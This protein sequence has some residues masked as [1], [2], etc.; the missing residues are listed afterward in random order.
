MEKLDDVMENTA[1]V[2]D[3]V[4]ITGY[5]MLSGTN[6]SNL[7][8]IV[9][10]FKPWEDRDESQE[11]IVQNIRAQLSKVQEGIATAF[12]P[13]A[14]DGL[15]AAGGFQMQLQDRGDE[16]EQC[17]QKHESRSAEYRNDACTRHLQT[18]PDLTTSRLVDCAARTGWR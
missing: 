16:D 17:G 13:P 8:L 7:G 2:E 15:G 10:I 14:I 1:G 4:S 5:S 9:I 18:V 6:G 12:I 3:W 11:E